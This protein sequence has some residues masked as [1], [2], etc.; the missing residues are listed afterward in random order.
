MT[1]PPDALEREIRDF[2]RSR[3]TLEERLDRAVR[4]SVERVGQRVRLAMQNLKR[5]QP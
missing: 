1:P 4:E 5:L 2:L 3:E